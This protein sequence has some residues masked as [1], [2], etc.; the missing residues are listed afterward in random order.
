MKNDIDIIDS[1][2]RNELDKEQHKTV[3]LRIE[4]DPEFAKLFKE[5]KAIQDAI[6]YDKLKS[7]QKSIVE[8][9]DQISVSKTAKKITL[10]KFLFSASA[11]CFLLLIGFFLFQNK[12]TNQYSELLL[13]DNFDEYI[14]HSVSRSST[15][16]TNYSKEQ[17]KAYNL[18]AIQE[19]KDA[20]PLCKI[21]WEEK[22][23]TLSYY[24]LGISLLVEG[25]IDSASK[26][27]NST[28]LKEYKNP[29][30]NDLQ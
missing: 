9:E 3:K 10:K 25:E 30:S 13:D 6:R 26:I 19:F 24:Y 23:D 5:T 21:L 1:F 29:I 4:K 17:L 16:N 15:Q 12:Q 8:L 27:L 14:Y 11:A 18:Y 28:I 20:M 7:V 22:N 2:L